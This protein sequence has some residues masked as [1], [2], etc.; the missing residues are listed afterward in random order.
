MSRTRSTARIHLLAA[1]EAPV[2]VIIRRKPSR[3]WHILQWDLRTDTLTP[4]SWFRGKLYPLRSDLSWDGKLMSYMAM[5]RKGE[6]WSGICEPPFLKTLVHWSNTSTFNGSAVWL[7]PDVIYRN[8]IWMDRPPEPPAPPPRPKTKRGLVS[9]LTNW[10]SEASEAPYSDGLTWNSIAWKPKLNLR[11]LENGT[12]EDFSILF[13]RLHRDGWRPCVDGQPGADVFD[14]EGRWIS[15]RK[16]SEV[17]DNEQG[18]IWQPTKRHPVLRARYAGH[19]NGRQWSGESVRLDPEQLGGR[20]GYILI[21]DLP[22]MPGI[23]TPEVDWATWT[24]NSQLIYAR[25]GVVYRYDLDSLRKGK[26]PVCIDLEGLVSPKRSLERPRG[27]A[28]SR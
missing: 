8:L 13:H 5:G 20:A 7:Q 10:L 2:A 24:R 21:F 15:G 18:W 9:K 11:V 27:K 23:L 6:V 28:I 16:F 22:D 12:A 4:G 25:Q 17:V 19:F 14:A 1:K 26:E 3:T